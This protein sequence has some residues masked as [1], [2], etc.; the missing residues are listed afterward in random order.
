[1]T[2][3]QMTLAKAEQRKY[4]KV[5]RDPRYAMHSPGA[6]LVKLFR[7]L[8]PEEG[9]LLDL[10]CGTGAAGAQ[11]SVL[12]YGVG[13]MD[14]VDARRH[15]A[16]ALPFTRQNLWGKWHIPV[17]YGYCCDVLEHIP[18]E[19]LNDVLRRISASCERCFF[20][21]HFRHD[22]FGPTLLG[23]PLHL[24]VQPFTWWRD[25]LGEL[26]E[27]EDARDLIGRGTFLVNYSERLP[28]QGQRAKAHDTAQHPQ[29]H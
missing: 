12:G 13:L 26:G 1:M 23:E 2:E 8:C 4:E 21:V 24:I 18:P 11:L 3:Q 16:T 28:G 14:F 22:V 5:W 29:K 7:E 15:F 20:G 25:K 10:G 19:R 17:D 6:E 9:T 27:V